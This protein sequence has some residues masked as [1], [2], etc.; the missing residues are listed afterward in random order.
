LH[1][2]SCDCLDCRPMDQGCREAR[3][4][5]ELE[6]LNT[7]GALISVSPSALAGLANGV[8]GKLVLPGDAAYDGV[9][10]VWNGMVDKRPALIARCAQ[11]S[12]VLISVRGGG[13]NY[14]GSSVS[15]GGMMIDLST[16]RAVTVDPVARAARASAGLRLGELDAAT[17]AHGLATTLGINTDTGIAGLTLGGGYG[18]LAGCF[19][20][21]CDNLIAAEVVTADGRCL[22]VSETEHP[23]LLW[24]LK[25]AGANLAIV[26]RLDYRLH[27]LARVLG[28]LVIYSMEHGHAALRLFDEFSASCPDEVST[29]GFL[30]HTHDGAPAVAIGLCYAG[31]SDK[32]DNVIAPLLNSVPVHANL[33]EFQPYTKL[34]TLF[35]VVWPP[36][37]LYYNKSSITRS[38][39]PAA[40][41]CLVMHGSSMPTK[42]SAIA[43]QQLHGVA[44]RVG[45]TETA[46]P[47]RFDHLSMYVHPATDNPE[48]ANTITEW[49][50][51][52]WADMQPFVEHAV[53]ANGLENAYEEGLHRVHEAYGGNYDRLVDLKTRYDPTNFL[54]GNANIR[55]AL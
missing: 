9:R 27:Q 24:G 44:A 1:R 37:R 46:F 30:V 33:L 6:I 41:D 20:L 28:G 16:M 36:G 38:L 8:V 43:F 55:P 51:R 22:T 13:H 5:R 26:T 49:C 54:S 23:D 15:Q 25:G 19:G 45:A 35:D 29:G 52:C 53:Y 34:Q 47:H 40:I 17:A 48:E 32:A 39:S 7:R 18:W 10:K 31:P 4:M 42:L 3:G 11:T 50:R 2:Q 12:D 21:A 14:A